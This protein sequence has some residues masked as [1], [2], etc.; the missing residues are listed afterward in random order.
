M[1]SYQDVIGQHLSICL[2]TK[3]GIDPTLNSSNFLMIEE[4]QHDNDTRHPYHDFWQV[5][6]FAKD[7]HSNYLTTLFIYGFCFLI[8]FLCS[9]CC[10]SIIS[11]RFLY[12]YLQ[13]NMDIISLINLKRNK[14]VSLKWLKAQLLCY[15]NY[16][17]KACCLKLWDDQY[18]GN[19][20]AT[21]INIYLISTY[22]F[23]SLY[24]DPYRH[25]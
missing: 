13:V 2:L 19:L 25:T 23:A 4:V 17:F 8:I 14:Y 24:L 6:I 18:L 22:L 9:F 10:L 1:E 16:N 3:Y 7:E 11:M 5:S 21:H 12:F 20:D 15:W